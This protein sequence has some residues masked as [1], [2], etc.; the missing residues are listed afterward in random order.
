METHASRNGFWQALIKPR[1]SLKPLSVQQ[2]LGMINENPKSFETFVQQLRVDRTDETDLEEDC[3]P[4]HH[5]DHDSNIFKDFQ[6][7]L[8]SPRVNSR[9]Q[10]RLCKSRPCERLM[11]SL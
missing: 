6:D 11:V 4:R 10:L 9:Q 2:F 1:K 7:H 3:D 8:E 5:R